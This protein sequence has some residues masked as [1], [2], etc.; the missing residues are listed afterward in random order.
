MASI[1]PP[2]DAVGLAALDHAPE[3]GYYR[4][5]AGGGIYRYLGLEQNDVAVADGNDRANRT[6]ERLERGNALKLRFSQPIT[7]LCERHLRQRL[8]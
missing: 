6:R 8:E 3:R 7:G 5:L 2:N 4:A 1:S